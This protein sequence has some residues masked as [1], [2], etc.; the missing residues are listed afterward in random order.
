MEFYERQPTDYATY[1]EAA[2]RYKYRGALG[3][4]NATLAQIAGEATVSPKYLR[5][6]WDLLE[7][8]PDKV[9]PVA[10]LQA[11]WRALPAAAAQVRTPDHA[12][13]VAMREF[14]VRIRQHTAMQFAAPVVRGLSPWSQP[15]INWKLRSYASHRRDFDRAA[16]RMASD[17]AP[18][19][20]EIPKYPG[21]GQEAAVRWAA[22]S[23]KARAD[24][25]DLII[26][27]GE[28]ASYE[29]SFARFSSVF[30]DQFYVK[31]RGRFFPD[32]SEDKGR[33]LSA[34]FHNVM[35][36]FRDDTP[37]AELI[38]DDQGKK[39]LDRLWDEFDFIADYTVRTWV[40]Y[41][42]NQ[43]GEVSGNGRESGSS[44][45]S[46][47]EVSAEAV[48]LGLRA[49]Y[50][51][52]AEPGHN[53]IAL[54]AI[55]DH[56]ERVNATIR[57][58]ERMRADAERLHLEALTKFAAKAYRRPLT[59]AERD[60]LLSYYQTLRTKGSLSHEEAIRDSVVSILMSPDFCYRLDLRDGS[61]S[62]MRPLSGFS[63]ANR[64]SYFLW[65]SMPD[66]ELLAH[67]AAGDLQKPDVLLA[68]VR[69]MSRDPRVRG[70]A[71]EFGGNWLDFRRFEQHNGVDR[72][73]FPAFTNELREAMFE[74]P[75]RMIEDAVQNDH[76]VLD[77]IYGKY[78]FAN[79][80]LAKHY[81]M[82][83]VAGSP[84]HWVRI[85]NA[86]DYGRGG[87]LPMSVFLTANSPGLRTS[88]VK[89]GNWVV[90]RVL[91][92]TIPPPPPVVPEL[93]HDESKTDLLVRDMLAK[94]RENPAC[95]GCHARFDSF[96]L[97]FEGYG[98][99]G[100]ARTKDLG[101][102]DVDTT[103]T[104]PGGS[105]GSGIQGVE[106]YIREHRQADYLENLS[107]KL[108]AY[109]LNRSLILSDELVVAEIQSKLAANGYRFSNLIETIVTSPQFLNRGS[110]PVTQSRAQQ[111]KGE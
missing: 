3:K 59:A 13:C 80:V 89:R 28:R 11:M 64:L 78:T 33:L 17:P 58:V 102:R 88:P 81:A 77:L 109:A 32:D 73:R 57:G 82:P 45:P 50:L 99:V 39:Q 35:G 87:L 34:G 1:F 53:A 20:P 8:A 97:A 56:F 66:A 85:D 46:D 91:G 40:Q 96:G 65:S 27:D 60:D 12:Q 62:G 23:L 67:A 15:L 90:R 10:K 54:E 14:A 6:I 19:V 22:L 74:E 37:L 21:L 86:N 75:V 30:P 105:D 41:F 24:D 108:L 71:T 76:S 42:F 107:R 4:P 2:W 43:S 94:H 93:P 29:A 38:L 51:A 63:L 47:K 18:I 98:P 31:E 104:F 69:R 16:L 55:R 106:T 103:A 68:Q 72:Q 79:P 61:T 84:D 44:R 7:S 101:G 36:Y 70:M 92:E 52:K 25:A 100:E 48:I 49:A 110:I 83:D 111:K 5:M 95:A 9:G 26:P